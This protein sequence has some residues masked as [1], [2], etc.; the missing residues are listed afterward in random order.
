MEWVQGTHRYVFITF[1]TLTQWAWLKT[2]SLHSHVCYRFFKVQVS[3]IP[4]NSSHLENPG[5]NLTQV[6][7]ASVRG[8]SDGEKDQRA[9]VTGICHPPPG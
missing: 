5:M 1:V 4:E 7:F 2:Y 6:I 8:I 9:S 3:K